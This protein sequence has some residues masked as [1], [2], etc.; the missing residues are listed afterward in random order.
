LASGLQ[1]ALNE[2]AIVENEL[3]LFP[4]HTDLTCFEIAH[5]DDQGA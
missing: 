5:M 2:R 4:Q 3:V 1:Q